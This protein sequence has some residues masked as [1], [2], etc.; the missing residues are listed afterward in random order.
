MAVKFGLLVFPP[1][2]SA[3]IRFVIGN[4]LYCRLGCVSWNSDVAEE[5]GV[6]SIDSARSPVCHTDGHL[7]YRIRPH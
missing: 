3:F 7:E 4:N 6:A 2:W 5:G 1:M